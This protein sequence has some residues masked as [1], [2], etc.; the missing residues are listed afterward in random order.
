MNLYDK[1]FTH[2][3]LSVR[4]SRHFFKK[5]HRVTSP[6]SRHLLE[7]HVSELSLSSKHSRKSS[8]VMQ[9]LRFI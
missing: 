3:L 2:S 5:K 1:E 7:G 4:V 6:S 9:Q 8:F